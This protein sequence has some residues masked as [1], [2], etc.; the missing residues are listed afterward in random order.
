MIS[1]SYKTKLVNLTKDSIAKARVNDSID[2]P[3]LLFFPS[4]DSLTIELQFPTNLIVN[5]VE[6]LDINGNVISTIS[7]LQIDT[8]INT[9]FSHNMQFLQGGV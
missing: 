6:F 7:G 2:I 9:V 4:A 3:N 1:T 5:K 8:A